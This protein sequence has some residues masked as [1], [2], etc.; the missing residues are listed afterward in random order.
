M[1][2]NLIKYFNASFDTSEL[3]QG[4]RGNLTAAVRFSC[5][6]PLYHER[7]WNLEEKMS[8]GGGLKSVKKRSRDN[9]QIETTR[10]ILKRM[11]EK[12]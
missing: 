9:E 3:N 4:A 8:N 7:N 5:I 11:S 12:K 6:R 1:K 10:S 2:R